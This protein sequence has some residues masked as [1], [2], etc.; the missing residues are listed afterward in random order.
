MAQTIKIMNWNIE[1]LGEARSS[2]DDRI[3]RIANLVNKYQPDIFSLIE[4]KTT[5]GDTAIKI[6][7]KILKKLKNTT[8]NK[9]YNYILSYQNL[10]ETYCYFYKSESVVPICIQSGI[11]GV[12]T[13]KD[14]LDNKNMFGEVDELCT[15][16][17]N[18]TGGFKDYFPLIE[19][20]D[21]EYKN[22]R[23][24]CAGF[25]RVRSSDKLF[26]LLAWH[27]AA[28][29]LKGSDE[30]PKK[31]MKNL[32]GTDFID[33]CEITINLK[34]KNTGFDKIIIS[35]DFNVDYLS[36]GRSQYYTDFDKF[37][38]VLTQ[39]NEKTHL[40]KYDPINDGNF[41]TYGDLKSALFDNFLI[42][43]NL[44]YDNE[45]VVDIPKYIKDS[46]DN[47]I[48]KLFED[49]GISQHKKVKE[50]IKKSSKVNVEKLLKREMV[51]KTRITK[52]MKIHKSMGFRGGRASTI[53][54]TAIN[55][56]LK[57]NGLTSEIEGAINK[58]SIKNFK[59]YSKAKKYI[60]DPS[61]IKMNDLLM[62]SQNLYSDH[63]PTIV[64]ITL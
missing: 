54:I 51:E 40:K 58:N 44:T 8:G 62:L 19:Y 22:M 49:S 11:S 34:G 63:L 42:S 25:F 23:P 17:D 56:I 37:E 31:E 64:E 50:R 35:G 9:P 57:D 29:S 46:G 16:K 45:E 20:D 18:N 30:K 21:R 1:Q 55:K 38:T 2:E 26:S 33:D 5:N 39:T 6:A 12:L 36:T 47:F 60:K 28:G 3:K 48:K 7:D 4:L 13:P 27:N 61:S 53:S 15:T 10:L 43:K 52:V 14:L 32:A 59:V 41:K 24:P